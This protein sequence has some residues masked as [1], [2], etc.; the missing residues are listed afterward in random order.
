MSTPRPP[1]AESSRGDS[2]NSLDS[3]LIVF[4]GPGDNTIRPA[5]PNLPPPNWYGRASPR[6][7][8]PPP[9]KG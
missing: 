4:D 5:R 3:P 8:P 7:Q 2:T 1:S 9:N 6:D